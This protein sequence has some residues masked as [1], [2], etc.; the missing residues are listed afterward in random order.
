MI[1]GWRALHE[2]AVAAGHQPQALDRYWAVEGDDGVKWLFVAHETDMHVA[3]TRWPDHRVWSMRKVCRVLATLSIATTVNNIKKLWP[4]A[5]VETIT[6]GP[7]P[8]DEIPL[9]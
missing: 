7:I 8:N 9:A 3:V 1:R 5:S 2:E 6:E 4:S